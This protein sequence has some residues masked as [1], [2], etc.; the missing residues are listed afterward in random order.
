MPTFYFTLRYDMKKLE[1]IKE[2]IR[3]SKEFVCGH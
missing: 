3:I 1:F 2:I